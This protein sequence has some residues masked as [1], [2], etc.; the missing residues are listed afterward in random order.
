MR[1]LSKSRS[2]ELIDTPVVAAD[3]TGDGDAPGNPLAA[4]PATADL[5]RIEIADEWTL[6]NAPWLPRFFRGL[7]VV[8]TM[9]PPVPFHGVA[10]GRLAPSKLAGLAG[11]SVPSV[12]S[13]LSAPTPA[14]PT[15]GPMRCVACENYSARILGGVLFWE[16]RNPAR[17]IR[18]VEC[19]PPPMRKIVAEIWV[20]EFDALARGGN[21]DCRWRW[22]SEVDHW[23]AAAFAHLKADDDR[24]A[25]ELVERTKR[26]NEGF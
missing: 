20:V 10:A 5:E 2:G 13:P 11:T 17:T 15:L 4:I 3:G 21:G 9:G 14:P 22:V 26:D 16:Q 8:Q 23:V 12:A 19:S 25:A 24:R 18:C 1:L 6:P 7:P